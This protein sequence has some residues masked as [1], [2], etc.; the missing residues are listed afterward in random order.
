MWFQSDETMNET[1]DLD[2]LGAILMGLVEAP[3]AEP[4]SSSSLVVE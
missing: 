3:G 4:P 1:R 2:R